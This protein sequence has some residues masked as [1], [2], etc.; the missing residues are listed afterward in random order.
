[1]ADGH[2]DP[3][4]LRDLR[5]S[6]LTLQDLRARE[7]GD[8]ERQATGTPGSVQGYVIPY[9]D[10]Q[11]NQIDFYR[12][13]LIEWEPKYRQLANKGNYIYFPP[14][15]AQALNNSRCILLVEGEKK[16]A[17]LIK[18]GYAAAAV[19]GVDSWRNRLI[20]IPKDSELGTGKK[21]TVVAKLPAGSE[22]QERTESLA[23][24]LFDLINIASKLNRPIVICYDTEKGGYQKREVQI[25]AASLGYELRFRGV[26]M[27]NIKAMQ[28]KAP[29][30]S[31]LDK[32]GVD[33]F[34]MCQQP[35]H[36]VEA[37]EEQ[38]DAVLQATSAFPLHPNI[39]EYVNKRLQAGRQDRKSLQ[40]LSTSIL[41]DLDAKGVRLRSPDD[42]QLYYFGKANKELTRV[43]FRL[44]DGFA[45]TPFGI[46]LYRDYNLSF[47][48]QKILQWL[49]S[50][51]SGEEPIMDVRPK[52]N[53]HLKGDNLYIQINA[54]EMVR[55]NAETIQF[56]NNGDHNILFEGESVVPLKLADLK[57]G[58]GKAQKWVSEDKVI[59]N[60]WYEIIKEARVQPS[61]EDRDR[62]IMSLLYSISP[63]FYRW[64]GT[65]LPAEMTIG[66]PGSGKSTLYIMRQQV[67]TGTSSLK[68]SPHDLKD[69]GAS[70]AG[71]GALHVTDNVHMLNNTLRQEISDEMCRV[72]TEPDPKIEKR[73]LYS[74]FETVKIPVESVFAITALKQPFNNADIIARSIIVEL[75]KGE[76]DVEFNTNWVDNQLDR[77]G[78]RAGWLANQLLFQQRIFQLVKEKWNDSYRAK[79]RLANVEQL[80]CLAAE[81]YGWDSSWIPGYLDTNAK[82]RTAA[83]D[84]TLA[85][86]KAFALEYWR[87]P[88]SKKPFF[89]KEIKEWAEDEDDFKDR[90]ILTNSRMLGKYI[91]GS[92][93]KI[94]TITGITAHDMYANAQRYILDPKKMAAIIEMDG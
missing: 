17:C 94:A 26:E 42:D 28:L 6:G 27:S 34:L 59:K 56:L 88:N 36:G 44:D 31:P 89:A 82:Q 83:G 61:E 20:T 40:H 76:E 50:Q 25:A 87:G 45:R 14:G 58:I 64:R 74:D 60:I 16:A 62:K 8:A 48:D 24:G 2:M 90:K 18:H 11:G 53:L 78:G 38:L 21:G 43:Q 91:S 77:F 1:M 79:F 84:E 81:A 46:K 10:M 63:W 80:L 92:P 49:S 32:V 29:S 52:R 39:R 33:D 70:V 72:I 35:L 69:W 51:Y 4:I 93:N 67:L 57:V 65:Q 66:E 75:Y 5:K 47:S 86:L 73:K 85:G 7:M 13:K 54:S 22:I 12:V 55:V 37:F 68:N 3:A 15:F 41:S 9:F 71:A 19:S 23:A 30:N